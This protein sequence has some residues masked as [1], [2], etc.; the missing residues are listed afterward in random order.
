MSRERSWERYAPGWSFWKAD[1][2][3]ELGM[4]GRRRFGRAAGG[5]GP[6]GL[7]GPGGF[8]PGA[9]GGGPPGG[10]PM[11]GMPWAFW[12]LFRRG[13]RAR[14]GDVR[15][16]ILLLLSEQQRNG[17]QIMRELE[18]RS[19]GT[20]RPSP[21]SVY[22]ALQ[23]LED[24]GLVREEASGLV[25]GGRVFALTDAG[26][27][28]V[29]AHRDELGAA[30]EAAN[31]LESDHHFIAMLTQVRHIAGA[32]MQVQQTGN[33]AQIA[34]AQKILADARRALYGL[35]AGDEDEADE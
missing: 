26:R 7:G 20:W 32:A 8:M 33:A 31:P 2:D 13:T 9:P 24:E 25:P 18:Q 28:Y 29:K 27:A 22:P 14:R 16:A 21:G 11:S 3:D 34:Q 23:Q 1:C 5:R 17:Y 6:G 19:R 10:F 35:L 4:A 15:S 30:W 12:S